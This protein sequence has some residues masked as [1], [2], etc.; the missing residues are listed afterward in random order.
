[1]G[2]WI[3]VL[4]GLPFAGV[5]AF[6]VAQCL[7]ELNGAHPALFPIVMFWPFAT[8]F[9]ALGWGLILL[10]FFG[11]ET[12][13]GQESA[14]AR[15]KRLLGIQTPEEEWRMGRVHSRG[16]GVVI[17]AWLRTAGAAVLIAPFLWIGITHGFMREE[18]EYRLWC[19]AGI[20][21]LLSLIRSIY[22][23]VGWRKFGSS[24]CDLERRPDTQNGEFR[25]RIQP[26]SALFPGGETTVRL[27]CEKRV[28]QGSGDHRHLAVTELWQDQRVL[29]AQP[30][31]MPI[32]VSFTI[33]ADTPEACP[34]KAEGIFWI[35][36]ARRPVR[37]IDYLAEFD[38]ALTRSL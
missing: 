27:R 5:G 12:A 21:L 9:S 31:G 4:V 10:G 29:P 3:L 16:K 35:L 2:L 25:C 32:E 6:A 37:G 17:A 23:T 34:Q 26:E 30:D 22:K 7:R 28:F 14:F 33:P 18:R 24:I 13:P 15:R 20:V 38:L 11:K 8:M 1:M 19:L 36:T